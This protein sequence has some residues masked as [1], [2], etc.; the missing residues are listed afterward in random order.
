MPRVGGASALRDVEV[1]V[2]EIADY[3]VR[4]ELLRADKLRCLARLDLLQQTLSYLAISTRAMLTA[5]EL[6][7][8]ARKRGRQSA[9]DTALDADMILAAQGVLLVADGHDVVIATSNVR[10]LSLFAPAKPW[11]EI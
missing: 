7:A 1:T 10:H 3:E 6:W 2:S 5:A 4:R 9:D 11:R 8:S